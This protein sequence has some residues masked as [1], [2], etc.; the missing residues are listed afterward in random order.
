MKQK[1]RAVSPALR[2]ADG[3]DGRGL[4]PSGDAAGFLRRQRCFPEHR[5]GRNGG[6]G[7][8]HRS[9]RHTGNRIPLRKYH[10]GQSAGR[11][12][13]HGRQNH[14]QGPL[15]RPPPSREAGAAA[16]PPAR[17]CSTSAA[18]SRGRSS[19]SSRGIPPAT[20]I[21]R[22]SRPALKRNIP[23]PPL[24]SST[25]NGEPGTSS[26]TQFIRN[27]DSPDYVPTGVFDFPRRAIKGLLTP[28]DDMIQ[29]TDTLDTYVMDKRHHLAGKEI[30]HHR[31]A[32][33]RGAVLQH[34]HVEKRSRGLRPRHSWPRKT[35]G[36]GRISR[37][38][39]AG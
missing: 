30:R 34:H 38:W 6:D 12:E 28:L 20:R 33:A 37:T 36:P 9:E 7:Y 21:S 1:I 17:S 39:R 4:R 24:R 16:T 19:C 18:A 3:A 5:P 27:G 32:I 15:P 8:D 29:V 2:A 22:P 11:K 13:D 35:S 31:Q 10:G 26:C 23:A 14:R 25:A